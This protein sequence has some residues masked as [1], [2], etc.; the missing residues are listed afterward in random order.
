MPWSFGPRN[1]PGMKMSQVEFVSAFYTILRHCTIEPVLQ[2]GE[3]LDQARHRLN[4]I[5]RDSLPLI[6]LQMQRPEEVRL[7]WT[8][9]G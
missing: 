7:R 3:S 8:R 9:R 6:T 5:L 2:D 4:E 1:C